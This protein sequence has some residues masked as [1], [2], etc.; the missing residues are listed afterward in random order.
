MQP[1]SG[2]LSRI[3]SVQPAKRAEACSLG[4][5]KALRAEPQVNVYKR[6]PACGAGGS[7]RELTRCRPLSGLPFLTYINPRV[8]RASSLHPGLCAHTRF[9][10]WTEEGDPA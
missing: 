7:R 10:R 8:P 5:S 1:A 4:W 6:I 2:P 3:L 9:A